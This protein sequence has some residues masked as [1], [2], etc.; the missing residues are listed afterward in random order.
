MLN[1]Q[2]KVQKM[3]KYFVCNTMFIPGLHVN[4]RYQNDMGSIVIG[5]NRGDVHASSAHRDEIGQGVV[6]ID[7]EFKTTLDFD[8]LSFD[9]LLDE[10]KQVIQESYASIQEDTFIPSVNNN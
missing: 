10:A 4:S 1:V 3:N 6:L 2:R 8:D 9:E 5:G 7:V